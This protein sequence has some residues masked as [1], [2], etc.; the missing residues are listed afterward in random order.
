MIPQDQ[1]PK[2]RSR[3]ALTSAAHPA[4]AEVFSSLARLARTNGK[5]PRWSAER[6]ASL[7]RQG[8]GRFSQKRPSRAA[9]NGTQCGAARTLCGECPHRASLGAPTP[10]FRMGGTF[11]SATL[12]G[13]I[14]DRAAKHGHA[15]L[16]GGCA[17]RAPLG[18][19]TLPLQG[20]RPAAPRRATRALS[21]CAGR[22][23]SRSYAGA[24]SAM[25]AGATLVSVLSLHHQLDVVMLRMQTL[26][27]GPADALG[28]ERG[29]GTDVAADARALARSKARRR[30]PRHG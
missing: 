14:A 29:K 28:D 5:M 18:G 17:S 3:G 4:A 23:P 25:V 24:T 12:V 21:W 20:R 11:Q 16:G 1:A 10:S 26:V 15:P 27:R 9:R 22:A 6:R 2:V 13:F 7:K 8:R 19:Q 30:G